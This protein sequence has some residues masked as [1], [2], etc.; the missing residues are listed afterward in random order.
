MT[1]NEQTSLDIGIGTEEQKALEPKPVSVLRAEIVKVGDKGNEILYV[2]VTHPDN[3]GEIRI[4]EV[5]YEGFDNKLKTSAL[6]INKDSQGLLKKSSAVV[7]LLKKVGVASPS[8]LI[9]KEIETTLDEKN[10]LAFKAY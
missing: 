2:Y 9:G 1:D 10:Y 3:S 8:Q 5:K 4:S 7:A 6:W